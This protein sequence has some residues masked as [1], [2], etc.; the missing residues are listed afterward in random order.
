MIHIVQPTVLQRKFFR[1]KG[2][3]KYNNLFN[4]IYKSLEKKENRN[5]Q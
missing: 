1:R 3:K 2:D 5:D 4:G